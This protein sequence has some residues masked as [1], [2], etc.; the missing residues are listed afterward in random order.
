MT[1]TVELTRE[2]RVGRVKLR[3][4]KGIQTLTSDTR[5]QLSNVLDELEKAEGLQVIVF[6]AEGRSF[7]A[8]A[9]LNEL[10]ALDH[11]T[12]WTF[13]RTGQKLME[14]IELLP[15]TTI[16]AVHA[17]CAGGGCELALACDMRL[18]A[19]ATR[20]G[21]PEVS[22]GLLP[23]WG[24]TVRATRLFGGAVARRMILAADLLPA[25]EA[26]RLG[27]IDAVFEDDKFREG[28]Q[29]RVD[30]LLSRA[31]QAQQTS[32]ALVQSFE[33]RPG[34]AR[35]QFRREARRFAACFR[36]NEPTEG[37]SAFLEK[38]APQ[39]GKNETEKT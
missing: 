25:E 5:Q 22:L 37:L 29:A 34:L 4:E 36:T 33:C 11:R 6:E 17:A 38:R 35:R 31:P 3:S 24:G 8:G 16:A 15:A 2:G 18:G 26:H 19:K 21:L 13:A 20:I 10:K 30:L 23:G 14:R 7:I 39:W 12:A 9:D 1:T 32:K 27:V 28:V